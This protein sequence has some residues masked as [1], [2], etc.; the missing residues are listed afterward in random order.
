M[1][2]TEFMPKVK[3]Y[4]QQAEVVGERVLNPA[5]FAV[6]ASEALVHQA[7]VAQMAN[8]RQVLAHTKTKGEVRGGGRKPWRQKGTGR[9]RAG[10]TRSPLWKGGGVTFGPRSNR[11]FT[12]KINIKMKRKAL[13]GVLSDRLKNNKLALVDK[14]EF[15]E[16]K[17]KKAAAVMLN[18]NNY[19]FAFDKAA[20]KKSA[21]AAKRDSKV[22]V[23]LAGRDEQAERAMRNLADVELMKVN[24]INIIDLLKYTNII[25]TTATVD[26]LEAV[27]GQNKK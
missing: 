27:Y 7:A 16:M 19:I 2:K 17:T 6:Q 18:F 1:I 22:L 24:N 15:P 4:N 13:L 11:N 25:M 23:M 14:L 26:K 10:S 21:K 9:A 5:V 12:K 20:A 3:V 8:A